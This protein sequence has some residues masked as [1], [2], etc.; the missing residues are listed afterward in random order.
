M[1]LS[2]KRIVEE[3]K[4]GNIVIEPFDERH[5]GHEF[6]RLSPGCMVFPG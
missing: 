4:N 3:M 1:L 6:L 5:L 2:D